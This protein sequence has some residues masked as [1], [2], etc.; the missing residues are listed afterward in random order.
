MYMPI[1]ILYWFPIALVPNYM[2]KAAAIGAA[3]LLCG[4]CTRMS[5]VHRDFALLK[6]FVCTVTAEILGIF[7]FGIL[8]TRLP[9]EFYETHDTQCSVLAFSVTVIFN[10]LLN[11]GIGLKRTGIAVK[12]RLVLTALIAALTAPYLFVV[13]E[14]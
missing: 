4:K 2:L 14:P 10:V 11:Y 3:L 1:W 8:E 12:H 5:I 9:I 7:T 13:L 6:C